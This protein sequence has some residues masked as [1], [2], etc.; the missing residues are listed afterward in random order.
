MQRLIHRAD[1]LYTKSKIQRTQ[2]LYRTKQ[3]TI[4]IC[5]AYPTQRTRICA[6]GNH[7]DLTTF[8]TKKQTYEHT[9][10]L[11]HPLLSQT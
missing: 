3:P 6:Y 8:R 7:Y 11:S 4:G 1:R 10:K 5:P 9:G 2:S